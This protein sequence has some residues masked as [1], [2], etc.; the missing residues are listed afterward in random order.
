MASRDS[1]D[2]FYRELLR[3]AHF[4]ISLHRSSSGVD[5]PMKIIDLFGAR[6]PACVLDYGACLSEQIQPG[7]TALTFRS[8]AEF[9]QQI[10]QL[11]QGFPANPEILDRMQRNINAAFP[12]TWQEAWQ[13]NAAPVF[14]RRGAGASACQP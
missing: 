8:S 11:L 3:A 5:L 9:A 7:R 2:R 14:H 1:P 12:E 4:G 13:R 10:D 6:T